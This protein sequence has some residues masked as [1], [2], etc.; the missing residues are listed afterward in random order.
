MK[1][2]VF[3]IQYDTDGESVDLPA[4]MEIEIPID[5]TEPDDVVDYLS[6]E[7][8]NRTGYCHFGFSIK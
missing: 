8:S 6:D 3:A 5:I 4:E 1:K 7:I 2:T